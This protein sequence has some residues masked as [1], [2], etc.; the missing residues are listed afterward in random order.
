[1]EM[2]SIGWLLPIGLFGAWLSKY[3]REENWNIGWLFVPAAFATSV[4]IW[5]TRRTQANLLVAS[6]VF[7]VVYALAYV[8]GYW[9]LGER[10]TN[11]QI[12]GMALGLVSIV[13]MNL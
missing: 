11:V 3:V 12:A 2:I 1:M 5:L 7:D 13:V 4:W 9:W 6:V 8:V 10:A